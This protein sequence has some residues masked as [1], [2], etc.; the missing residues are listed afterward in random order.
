MKSPQKCDWSHDDDPCWGEIKTLIDSL[1]T[2]DGDDY[3][4]TVHYCE[5][6][7]NFATFEGEGYIKMPI[8]N[9]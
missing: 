9:L 1:S 4:V 8:D 3:T 6:H 2:D 7:A 5:G